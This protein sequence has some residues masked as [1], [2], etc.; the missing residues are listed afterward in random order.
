MHLIHGS[1]HFQIPCLLIEPMLF[2]AI[3][4]WLTGLR[5]T[6][7]ALGL[8]LLV[9]IFT[10][11]VSTACGE[12]AANLN[13]LIIYLFMSEFCVSGCFFSTVYES[14]PLAMAYL[15]P[16]DYILTITMGPFIKLRYIH[17]RRA[18]DLVSRTIFT[19]LT[20]LILESS[21]S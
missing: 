21:S 5:P 17:D 7:D 1:Q 11:N 18:N 3:M 14:V 6:T 9:V 4:Y 15:V 13:W 8:T 2:T 12:Y 10:M 16:F 19:S 20:G